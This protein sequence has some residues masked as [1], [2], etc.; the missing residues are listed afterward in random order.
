MLQIPALQSCDSSVNPAVQGSPKVVFVQFLILVRVPEP[1]VTEHIEKVDHS[2]YFK[3]PGNENS[4]LKCMII[5]WLK[6]RLFR[7][8]CDET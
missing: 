8:H 6:Y 4:Y 5:T 1:Q 7:S 3:P 2:P